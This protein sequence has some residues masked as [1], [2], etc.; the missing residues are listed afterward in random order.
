MFKMSGPEDVLCPEL[1]VLRVEVEGDLEVAQS[2]AHLPD[3]Q[4]GPTQ[5]LVADP[6]SLL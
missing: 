5:S 6:P 1:F 4:L 2:S 3:T